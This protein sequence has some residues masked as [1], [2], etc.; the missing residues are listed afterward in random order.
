LEAIETSNAI[1]DGPDDLVRALSELTVKQ[2]SAAAPDCARYSSMRTS[3]GGKGGHL[4]YNKDGTYVR[5]AACYVVAK[6]RA[7]GGK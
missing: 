4:G 2:L 6:Y 3:G 7:S 5:A 1:P